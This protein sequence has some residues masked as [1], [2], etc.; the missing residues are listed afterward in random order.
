M[1]RGHVRKRGGT[2]SI[3][4]DE[5]SDPRSGER[6]QRER[7]GFESKPAAEA[8]LVEALAAIRAGKYASPSD[9]TVHQFLT[10]WMDQKAEDDLK[11]TT[12]HSYRT[13]I[14]RHLIP[15]LGDLR[16][17]HLDVVTIQEA[18]RDIHRHGGRQG[19]ALSL[20]TVR[21]CRGVLRQAL[22]EAIVLGLIRENP[23]RLA[24]VASRERPEWKPRNQP[25]DPWTIQEAKTFLDATSADRFATLWRL[26]LTTGLRRGEA[27]ALRWS[28]VDLEHGRLSVSKNR[29]VAKDDQRRRLVYEDTP[30]SD[31]SRRNV[32]F[33]PSVIAALRKHRAT[34]AELRLALAVVWV[35]EDRVFADHD[36][37]GLDPD[38]VSNVFRKTCEHIGVRPIRLHDLRHLCATRMLEAGTPVEV[39]SN[40]LGH[41]RTSVT[42][43]MYVH[44]EDERQRAAVDSFDALFDTGL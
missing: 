4:Y 8:G 5:R 10:D 19:A 35:D 43:D 24:K 36:G 39:V 33:G 7:G 32:N 42:L 44:V 20:R 41:A 29:T 23:A 11:P 12:A 17:Q 22:D 2:W 30:K 28:D 15:R 9:V 38:Y 16:I 21:Y 1:S 37:S 18:L 3:V 34:Q 40:L 26:Y 25:K 31:K 27:L 14:E 6:R 13:K